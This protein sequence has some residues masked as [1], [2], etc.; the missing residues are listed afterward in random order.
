MAAPYA[1][2]SNIGT[3]QEASMYRLSDS[4]VRQEALGTALKLKGVT[5]SDYYMCHNY[6]RD[7]AEWW[8]CRAAEMAADYGLVTRANL[9][10]RPHDT[11]TLAE[12][13]G[14]TMNSLGIS[15]STTSTATVPGNI[16]AW[17]KRL[18]LTLEEQEI[19]LNVR[20]D[21][22]TIIA[23]SDT[24]IG[25]GYDMSHRLTRGQFFQVV[26]ALLHYSENQNPLA[27]CTVYND[28]CND[29][30]S[31]VETTQCTE[32]QCFWK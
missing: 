15:L 28:G 9:S 5:L 4:L 21:N 30:T 32:R 1:G 26:V 27:H 16:P 22:G 7:T 19:P 25:S 31:N 6:F 17:Q 23:L 18:I 8:V 11:L 29:C 14:I 10:F 2:D 20:D 12:S 3:L 13:L 24:R